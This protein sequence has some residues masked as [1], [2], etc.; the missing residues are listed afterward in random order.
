MNGAAHD[1][2]AQAISSGTIAIDGRGGPTTCRRKTATSRWSSSPT[3]RTPLRAAI[4]QGPDVF[5]VEPDQVEYITNGLIVPLDDLVNW[6][7]IYDWARQV[8]THDGK[9][10]ALP[11]EA[12][13]DELYYN[14]DLL[15]KLGAKLPANAQL[16][17][18]NSSSS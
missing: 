5:Y 7:N 3:P 8:W 18:T 1:R 11:E 10:W 6:N 13:T 14:K 16:T 4:G 15:A 17:R 12:Y 9:T 2:R